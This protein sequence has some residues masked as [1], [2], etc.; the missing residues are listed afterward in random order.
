MQ[1]LPIP[2]RPWELVSQD[3][4]QHYSTNYLVTV[5]HFS[6]WIECDQLEDTLSTTIIQK[7]KQHFA[8]YGIPQVCHTDN[9][10]QFIA[11]EYKDFATSWG[12]THSTSSLY[13][14]Q[15]NGKAESTVK[16]CKNFLKKSGNL[17]LSLLHTPP[18]GHT[19][20]PA[21]RMLSRRTKTTLY[22]RPD[23][24]LPHPVDTDTTMN[25]I[26]LKKATTKR[27]YDKH[28][29]PI[30]HT[31][32]EIGTTVYAKPPPE[33]CSTPRKRGVAVN[34]D[35]RSYTKCTPTHTIR[36]NHVHITQAPRK[37]H[38]PISVPDIMEDT[39]EEDTPSESSSS[40]FVAIPPP[41]RRCNP[42]KRLDL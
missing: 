30:S 33:Q 19:Y 21:Q 15:G 11:K 37:Q 12:F 16:V 36:R 39:S 34:R 42:P 25:K 31:P 3:I 23:L 4:F 24:L 27:Q 18:A 5:C 10:P 35:D 40:G 41:P 8:R 32:I 9:D 13:H 14:P 6:D 22:T 2:S 26:S 1:S 20:S 38:T 7:T 17:D 28:A 29:S